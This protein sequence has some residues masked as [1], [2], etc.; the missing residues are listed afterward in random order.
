MWLFRVKISIV[1]PLLPWFSSCSSP[2]I[3]VGDCMHLQSQKATPKW[4]VFNKWGEW[5]S[6]LGAYNWIFWAGLCRERAKSRKPHPL[7]V[8]SRW[9]SKKV[10]RH[11]R[12]DGCRWQ[13]TEG[14]KPHQDA[15]PGMGAHSATVDWGGKGKVILP[16]W[17]LFVFTPPW[18][19][20]SGCADCG[21]HH[22]Q[23][24]PCP[25]FPP[26]HCCPYTQTHVRAGQGLPCISCWVVL[27]G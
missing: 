10:L 5:L 4:A 15:G 13:G 22:P 25:L 16:P 8:M 14:F 9:L 7:F 6:L 17:L 18:Q 26:P 3:E 21:C 1:P 23:T 11:W 20:L 27:C 19:S 12:D 24:L 2:Q